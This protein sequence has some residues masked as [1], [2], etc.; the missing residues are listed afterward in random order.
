MRTRLHL[1]NLPHDSPVGN[2]KIGLD[3]LC[4]D[5]PL[6]YIAW[7]A[8]FWRWYREVKDEI[9]ADTIEFVMNQYAWSY[10]RPELHADLLLHHG[11]HRAV[12]VA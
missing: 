9:S 4:S 6:P 12:A 5:L 3:L 11:T 2:L 1:L 7:A 10:G 8:P